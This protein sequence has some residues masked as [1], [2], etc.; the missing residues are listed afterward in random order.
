MFEESFPSSNMSSS[1]LLA[2]QQRQSTVQ[3]LLGLIFS[4]WVGYCI[5]IG[6]YRLYFQPI[7]IFPGP[8]LA[9]LTGWY[10][11]YFDLVK[12]GGGQF[13]FEIKRM[14][15]V[16]G[17]IVRINPNELHVDDP[18]YCDIL[19]P[20]SKPYDKPAHF[21]HRFEIPGATFS[22][23]MHELHKLRRNAITP[24]FAKSKIRQKAS[25]I[26]TLMNRVSERFSGEYAGKNRVLNVQDVWKCFAADNMMDLVYGAPLNLCESPEF[27]TNFTD[28]IT[29]ATQWSHI[30]LY[31]SWIWKVMDNM[32]YSAAMFLFPPFQ[33]IIAY[34]QVSVTFSR[35]LFR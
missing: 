20:T 27:K 10:K 24:F 15:K 16:Y 26:Q 11:G 5:S 2:L 23:P 7:A 33:P 4:G 13:P 28:A 21:Q 19:Y 9:A 34:R 1:V 32:P 30:T 25:E 22:T 35:N 14:H 12:R 31:F 3:S 17:P 6:F 29:R 8:K 18:E